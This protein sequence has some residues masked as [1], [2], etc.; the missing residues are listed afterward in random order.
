MLLC[1][2]HAKQ[3]G[4]SPRG[5]PA[6][7]PVPLPLPRAGG[8]S[9]GSG[10]G[11]LTPPLPPS[12]A[13]RQP[14]GRQEPQGQPPR[15]TEV[16]GGPDA[17]TQWP[18][19]RSPAPAAPT[20]SLTLPGALFAISAFRVLSELGNHSQNTAWFSPGQPSSLAFWGG[21]T[22]LRVSAVTFQGVPG[23]L[24]GPL[25][26]LAWVPP[27]PWHIQHNPEWRPRLG[28]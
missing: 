1:T 22:P 13:H 21:W 11:S 10:P 23:P 28:G 5:G 14:S 9:G 2:P 17:R 7:K 3:T 20:E 24:P 6:P 12:P 16:P 15:E 27:E 8:G 19:P 18:D 4:M 25:P 26:V